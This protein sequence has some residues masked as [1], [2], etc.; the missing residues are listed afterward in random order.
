MSDSTPES[1]ASP[2][3]PATPTSPASPA[4][5]A[6]PRPERARHGLRIAALVTGVLSVL[7]TLT[8]VV[9]AAFGMGTADNHLAGLGEAVTYGLIF[10]APVLFV[11]ALNLLSWRALL[12]PL[13]R[14]SVGGR[15]ALIVV[16]VVLFS[17]VS[18]ALVALVLFGGFFVG[19][20]SSAGS[21]F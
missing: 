9:L 13:A 1:P 18:V 15:I 5:G 10:A 12:R 19:A 7:I 21:G 4:T 16:L 11:I 6:D 8:L 17:V 3:G 20:M 2:Y 14:M